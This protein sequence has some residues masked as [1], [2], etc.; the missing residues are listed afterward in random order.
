MNKVYK[1][2]ALGLIIFSI[3]T[4]QAATA[5]VVYKLTNEK[6]SMTIDGTSTLHDWSSTV[7]EL[8]GQF[9]LP[10][11]AA[12]KLENGAAIEKVKIYAVVKS[13]ESG[14]GST[15]DNRTHDAL[16]ADEHPKVMFELTQGT[17]DQ[18]KGNEFVVN[19]TGN[20]NIAGSSKP[21]VMKVT[22]KKVDENTF[23][24]SGSKDIDMTEFKVDPPTAMFGQIEAGKDVAIKFDLVFSR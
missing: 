2:S 20:L 1:I 10:A 11:K 15:M 23:R 17:I 21:I 4:F 24:F 22:G 7:N 18:L 6:S 3:I 13:I 8:E 12:K 5:Q 19:A 14:R 9:E 16:K